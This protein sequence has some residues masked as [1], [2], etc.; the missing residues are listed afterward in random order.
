MP[1]GGPA[2]PMIDGTLAYGE[3]RVPITVFASEPTAREMSGIDVHGPEPDSLEL[4]VKVGDNFHTVTAFE[5]VTD[6]GKVPYG[7]R[8]RGGVTRLSNAATSLVWYAPTEDHGT[9][10]FSLV[11]PALSGRSTFGEGEVI[12]H[13]TAWD[14]QGSEQEVARG[15]LVGGAENYP[16]PQELRKLKISEGVARHIVRSRGRSREYVHGASQQRV[17]RIACKTA[18]D[19]LRAS[20]R[21]AV[22]NLPAN[23]QKHHTAGLPKAA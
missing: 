10:R 11:V 13:Q 16:L 7:R 15:V 23:R 1:S 8:H 20:A 3:S 2:L 21:A 19:P 17:G 6:K 9:C 22:H 5:L 18:V 4:V 12:L 14:Q